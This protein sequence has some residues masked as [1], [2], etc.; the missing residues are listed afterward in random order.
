MQAE[1]RDARP[2]Q[3]HLS[4]FEPHEINAWLEEECRRE[5]RH[6]QRSKERPRRFWVRTDTATRNLF[7]S[8]DLA[9]LHAPLGGP[10]DGN[11]LNSEVDPLG[12]ETAAAETLHNSD[13]ASEEWSDGA[14]DQLHEAVLHYSLKA[15]QARGNGAEKREILQWIFAP[16]PMVIQQLNAAGAVEE[17]ALPQHLTPFSF[18]RCCRICRL[19]SEN[20]MDG[21]RPILDEMGLGNFFNELANGRNNPNYPSSGDVTGRTQDQDV[22]P[23]RNLQPA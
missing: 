15:L 14:V 18:E 12:D 2:F 19:R 4:L 1:A 11:E 17:V 21:L 16:E 13:P 9:L 7:D 8:I 22:P 6:E 20:L 3:L 10:Q 23:A 5:R